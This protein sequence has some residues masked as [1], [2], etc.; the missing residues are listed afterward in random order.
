MSAN[1][2]AFPKARKRGRKSLRGPCA[3]LLAFP[4]PEPQ[5]E[6]EAP[7]VWRDPQQVAAYARRFQS[8]MTAE[9]YAQASV[10]G[11]RTD[12]FGQGSLPYRWGKR[13]AVA[14]LRFNEQAEALR[15]AVETLNALALLVRY[16]G[17][18]PISHDNTRDGSDPAVMN[19]HGVSVL[20]AFGEA[21][22]RLRS[23]GA[24]A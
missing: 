24:E 14:V 21:M 6:P 10:F 2:L 12:H 13:D 19:D 4:S 15:L 7:I 5:E 16:S 11:C 1:V 20:A 23:F 9:A 17:L 18:R 8:K 3:T 22:V